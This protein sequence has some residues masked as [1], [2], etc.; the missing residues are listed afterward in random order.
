M[1]TTPELID[2]LA[3]NA[4]PVRRLRAPVVRAACWLLFAVFMLAMV[5]IVHGL[6]SDL[7]VRLDEPIFVFG[8]ASALLTGALAA[9]AS[10]FVSLPDRSRLWMF[11]PL[12]AF[13]AWMSTISYGCL[14]H[15][16]AP[17]P[18]EGLVAAEAQCLA[19]MLLTSIPLSLTMLLMVRYAAPYRP[20]PVVIM[21]SLA[22]AALVAGALSV[23]HDHNA[24]AMVLLWNVGVTILVVGLGGLFGRSALIWIAP[25]PVF[26]QP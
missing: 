7:A 26:G 21:G 1:I 25:R 16:V 12:P 22:V 18:T 6:R 23:F 3:S 10:F 11:L 5:A 13:L 24:A 19:L 2:S 17:M 15:W 9:I 20:R 4:G 8:L 14:T